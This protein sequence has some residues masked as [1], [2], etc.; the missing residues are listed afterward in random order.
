MKF[1]D[2]PICLFVVTPMTHRYQESK[3]EVPS[4]PQMSE[5][6]EKLKAQNDKLKDELSELKAKKMQEDLKRE[7]EKLQQE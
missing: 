5:I 1:P 6:E 7:N 3:K 4:S 2:F